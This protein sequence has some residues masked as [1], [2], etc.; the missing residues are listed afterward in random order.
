MKKSAIIKNTVL[1]IIGS[2]FNVII[3]GTVD[4]TPFPIGDDYLKVGD[5]SYL[6]RIMTSGSVTILEDYI[7]NNKVIF[8]YDNINNL[9]GHSGGSGGVKTS[10]F[11][12]K[13]EDWG[14]V[15]LSNGGG[16]PWQIAY[17]LYQYAR[18]YESIS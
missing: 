18:D 9:W 11:F 12:D 2:D 5:V 15:V 16:E 3:L 17:M 1:S 4:G 10:M 6:D 13:E 8:G 14:V 7:V